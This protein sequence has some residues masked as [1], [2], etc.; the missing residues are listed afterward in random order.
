M[1]HIHP[2]LDVCLHCPAALAAASIIARQ[3]QIMKVVIKQSIFRLAAVCCAVL[4]PERLAAQVPAKSA[5]SAA[6]LLIREFAARWTDSNAVAISNL[7]MPEADLV[8]PTGMVASGR[9][10]IRAFYASAF[11]AGYAGSIAGATIEH[12]RSVS[13]DVAIVDAAWFI[14]RAKTPSG[15]QA[16]TERG[17]LTAVI[18][19]DGN[20]W[21]IIA[22]R[23]QTSATAYTRIPA[24][25]QR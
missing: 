20:A 16:P 8:I 7:F 6:Y 25:L 3:P 15:A 13:S 1:Q 17:L 22:L 23:E 18:C 5:D 10:A 2:N 14:A 19:R 12:I 21:G 24:P 9:A 11:A 4:G